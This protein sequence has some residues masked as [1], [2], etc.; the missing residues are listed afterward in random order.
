VTLENEKAR[1]NPGKPMGSIT[2]PQ[3][4]Y[5]GPA[6]G[7]PWRPGG[8]LWVRGIFSFVFDFDVFRISH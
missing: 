3:G 2:F 1:T 7:F 6:K 8:P 5:D 4:A